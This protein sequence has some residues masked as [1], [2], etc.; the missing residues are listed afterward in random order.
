MEPTDDPQLRNLLRLWKVENAPASLDKRVL[1]IRK[2]WWSFLVTGSLRVPVPV[3]LALVV[4]LAVMTAALMRER[5]A[6]LPPVAASAVNLVNF[7][8][9]ENPQVRIIGRRHDSQ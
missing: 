4:V 6:P 8:P 5:R 7:R 9:V 3:A 2:P 1:A